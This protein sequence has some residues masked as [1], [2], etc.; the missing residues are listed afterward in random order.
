MICRSWGSAISFLFRKPTAA[1][2]GFEFALRFARVDR[3]LR[4]VAGFRINRAFF[5]M[6]LNP[7]SL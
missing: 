6:W 7:Q 1:A 4:F 5:R 2:A 3:R